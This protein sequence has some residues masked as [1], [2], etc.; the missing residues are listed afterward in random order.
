MQIIQQTPPSLI[1]VFLTL[2]ILFATTRVNA[3]E[4]R[5]IKSA[6]NAEDI[7]KTILEYL[8]KNSA[9]L[10]PADIS[11]IICYLLETIKKLQTENDK[12]RF[13]NEEARK[14]TLDKHNAIE[15]RLMQVEQ[16]KA[17]HSEI[18]LSPKIRP[19]RIPRYDRAYNHD[20]VNF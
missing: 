7:K 13:E 16:M 15:V 14:Q 9:A 3:Q 12:L 6:V 20:L 4:V 19:L 11:D 5:P 10:E 18:P 8:K 17:D 2:L 1:C